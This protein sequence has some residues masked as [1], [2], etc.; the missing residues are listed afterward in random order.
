MRGWLIL[1]AF[2]CASCASAR[3]DADRKEMTIS[4]HLFVCTGVCESWA[5]HLGRGRSSGQIRVEDYNGEAVSF[6]G[7]SREQVEW[8]GAAADLS[9]DTVPCVPTPEDYFVSVTREGACTALV[10][11]AADELDVRYATVS[12]VASWRP[13][14]ARSIRGFVARIEY[15]A[16]ES[17][18]DH[19]FAIIPLAACN[20]PCASIVAWWQDSDRSLQY[21]H[22]NTPGLSMLSLS[23]VPSQF[24]YSAP[25]RSISRDQIE[26]LLARLESTEQFTPCSRLLSGVNVTAVVIV[27]HGGCRHAEIRLEGPEQADARAILDQLE[28]ALP[29][30][31][32][33]YW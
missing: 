15:G 3:P 20:A 26:S 5:I 18:P 12:A 10:G 23:D 17:Q 9:A 6:A 19:I 4:E 32:S 25:P 2:L 29:W 27:R 8:I 31:G 22:V 28:A 16:Q 1:F 14:L 21:G 7:I 33:P 24:G 13:S 11:D 30:E